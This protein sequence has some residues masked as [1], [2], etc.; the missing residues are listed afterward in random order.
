[1]RTLV[2]A[3]VPGLLT[4]MRIGMSSHT[5]TS[6]GD[7]FVSSIAGD[8]TFVGMQS[9]GVYVT[10]EQLWIMPFCVALPRTVMSRD[11]PGSSLPTFHVSALPLWSPGGLDDSYAKPSAG[12][13][14]V[15]I[16]SVTFID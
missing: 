9:M 2:A 1:M 6:A 15:T 11:W 13:W 4:T 7:V 14:S 3:P 10:V 5:S 12:S 16:T 8:T